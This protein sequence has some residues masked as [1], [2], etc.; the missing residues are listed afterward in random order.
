MG[1]VVPTL[2]CREQRK[3]EDTGMQLDASSSIIYSWRSIW[4]KGFLQFSVRVQ[5]SLSYPLPL[6][7]LICYNRD[8]EAI[9][10]NLAC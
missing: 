7:N 5:V 3:P 8:L 10:E 9:L 4:E 6:G 1:L 2:K